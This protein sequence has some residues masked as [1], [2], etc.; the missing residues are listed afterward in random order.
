M[1]T[2]LR[3][4]A[5]LAG[6]FAYFFVLTLSCA[7]L[8]SRGLVAAPVAVLIVGSAG[9]ALGAFRAIDWVIDRSSRDI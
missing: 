4:A 7:Y 5:F 2:A 6:F 1:R 9:M 3:I 8:A